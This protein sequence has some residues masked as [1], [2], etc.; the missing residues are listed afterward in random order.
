MIP[1]F[2]SINSFIALAAVL[3][4]LT[5]AAWV[6]LRSSRNHIYLTFMFVCLSVA[7]WNF[8]DFM[9][10]ATGHPLWP[11]E[12]GVHPSFWKYYGSVGSAMAVSFLFHFM[13]ALV[14]AVR[15]LQGWI[16]A[17][18]VAGAFFSVTSPM[19]IYYEP[20]RDFVNGPAW[21]ILFGL[22]LVPLI[23]AGMFMLAIAAARAKK[24]D[25]RS[26]WFF[27]LTA[28]GIT[29]A[30]G[31]TDLVQKLQFPVPPL[32]H[33]GSVIGPGVP[34]EW[35]DRVFEPFFTTKKEGIG[36]GLAISKRI[37]DAHNGR[38]DVVKDPD[39]GAHFRIYLPCT[40]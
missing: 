22:T 2:E 1:D 8:G 15:R 31:L 6:V 26:R 11:P 3:V 20:V 38:I 24:S 37:I 29:V 9:I 10:Y 21:N 36:V 23:F 16:L 32:G 28:I 5:L 30:G 4:N 12:G 13:C 34:L 33:T 35:H 39:G 7:F 14:R 18:Y 27:T 25:E 17:G 40:E 19:A